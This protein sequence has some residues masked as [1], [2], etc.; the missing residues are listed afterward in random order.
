MHQIWLSYWDR[1]QSPMTN[2]SWSVEGCRFC[3]GSKI[4]I[5]YWQSQLPAVNRGLTVSHYRAARDIGGPMQ[6][7]RWTLTYPGVILISRPANKSCRLYSSRKTANI[8][9]HATSP[10]RCC[11]LPVW[12]DVVRKSTTDSVYRRNL[13]SAE[14][15]ILQRIAVLPAFRDGRVRKWPFITRR[16]ICSVSTWCYRFAVRIILYLRHCLDWIIMDF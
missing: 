10:R 15:A 8:F 1:Q 11:A 6:A 2:F 7:V 9:R 3:I 5:P 13:I 14:C 16:W 12:G 4:G